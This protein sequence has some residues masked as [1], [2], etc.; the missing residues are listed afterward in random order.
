MSRTGIIYNIQRY[1]LH[2]GPGIRTVVFFKGCPLRCRWCCNPES[3]NLQPEIFYVPSKCL[4]KTV[5]EACQK[6]CTQGAISFDSQERAAIDRNKCTN[7]RCCAE[8]CPA[9]A[10]RVEGRTVTA[11]DILNEVEKESV[12]YRDN[13]GGL[14][15]SGGEPLVQGDFLLTLLRE[16]KK[17]RI[18]TAMETCG[19]GDYE[20]LK[21][22]ASLLDTVFYDIK[23][24]NDEKHR[25]WT[26]QSNMRILDNFQKLCKDYPALPKIVR[27]PVIPGF[28]DSPE[29][30]IQIQAFSRSKAN[31]TFELLP[32]HRF[33]AGKYAALGREYTV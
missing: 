20:T 32:Y 22:A 29:E 33:G 27:T 1:A 12:F 10:I 9:K 17:R 31:V 30:L 5:C 21:Q 26:K 14:T 25:E 8:N 2:D 28:N 23:S 3:Q 11:Y 7:C 6:G 18:G 24:L 4:G 13:A 15:I 19:F 16:A